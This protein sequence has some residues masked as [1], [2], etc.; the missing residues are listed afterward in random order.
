MNQYL[1]IGLLIGWAASLAGVGWWQ[2]EAGHTAERTAW[3]TRENT[4]L[5]AAN[6]KIITLQTSVRSIEQAHAI[7]LAD[8]STNYQKEL[9]NANKQHAAD[10]AAVRAG[11]I[12]LRYPNTSSIYSI[13]DRPAETGPGTGGCDGPKGA[14][15]PAAT[16][17]FLLSLANDAD[18]ITRQ[19]TA[20][21]R[22]IIE[23]RAE[24]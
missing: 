19:L 10:V 14:E 12:R 24:R 23:D 15:L 4:E 1:I 17:E 18:D 2:N 16:S 8:V 22:V 7:A 5:R 13:G 6:A 21:Q 3:Q 11:A 20:C 9:S